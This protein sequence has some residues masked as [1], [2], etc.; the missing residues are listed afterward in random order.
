[1]IFMLLFTTSSEAIINEGVY[2]HWVAAA[3]VA[4]IIP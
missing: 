4:G 1:M 3:V 2:G